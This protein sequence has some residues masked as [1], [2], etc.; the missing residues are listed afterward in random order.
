MS[1]LFQITAKIKQIS[2]LTTALSIFGAAMLVQMPHAKAHDFE[3]FIHEESNEELATQLVNRFWKNVEHQRTKA[4]SNLLAIGFQGLNEQG[5]YDREDQIRG[6]KHSTLRS[7]KIKHLTAKR[8]AETLVISY[9]F[10]AHGK[11]LTS[12]PSIDVWHRRNRTWKL[13]SHSYVPFQ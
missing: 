2:L 5:H 9:D 12:G 8:Y 4:Y 1:V 3:L 13:I 7:F 11:G 6:L 10:Y